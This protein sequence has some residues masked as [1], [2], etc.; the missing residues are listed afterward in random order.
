[1]RNVR[2]HKTSHSSVFC[3][4]LLLDLL[5]PPRFLLSSRLSHLTAIGTLN[6]QQ[7]DDR[8]IIVRE[9]REEAKFRNAVTIVVGGLPQD[10]SWQNVKDYFRDC[11]EVRERRN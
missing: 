4:S 10:A 9:D 3:A 6:E 11:G 2:C 8:Y 7:I 1:M 5:F